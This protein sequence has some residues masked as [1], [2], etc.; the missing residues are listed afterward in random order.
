MTYCLSKKSPIS[1]SESKLLQLLDKV[2]P[3]ITQPVVHKWSVTQ[4][5]RRRIPG[6]G[7]C[8]PRTW[9]HAVPSRM[10]VL[11][12]EPDAPALVQPWAVRRAQGLGRLH[13]R[14][15]NVSPA[16]F[17][18]NALTEGVRAASAPAFR[19]G[20][21]GPHL[22]TWVHPGPAPVPRELGPGEQ[23]SWRAGSSWVGG[24]GSKGLPLLLR[25]ARLWAGT[26]RL[27]SGHPACSPGV[28]L[29]QVHPGAAGPQPP[30]PAPGAQSTGS[31]PPGTRPPARLSVELLC[32]AF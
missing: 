15:E 16:R 30:T 12:H 9:G 22:T 4:V 31:L 27:W 23:S 8:R 7:G 25:A 19:L 2:V 5:S 26:R 21:L 29:R 11:R 13:T 17:H 14:S 3:C 6:W 1:P 20:E 32:S 24:V 18:A 28:A 10:S